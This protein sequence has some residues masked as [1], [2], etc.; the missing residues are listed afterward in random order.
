MS[1]TLQE[2]IDDANALK[3]ESSHSVTFAVSYAI[4][5]E[6]RA[7]AFVNDVFVG[8]VRK[9]EYPDGRVLIIFRSS[10]ADSYRV[11]DVLR[12][13]LADYSE[14]S[15]RDVLQRRGVARYAATL[16][17]AFNYYYDGNRSCYNCHD[18][19]TEHVG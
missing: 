19:T 5:N 16:I 17:H 15:V 18:T 12:D 8:Y 10:R 9:R 2:L 7:K 4:I 3:F 14:L 1:K 11:L 6:D 13:R